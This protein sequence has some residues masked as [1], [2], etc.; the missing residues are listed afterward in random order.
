M[1]SA[2]EQ[3]LGTENSDKTKRCFE[4]TLPWTEPQNSRSSRRWNQD[5]YPHWWISSQGSDNSLQLPCCSIYFQLRAID[6]IDL[7]E[8]EVNMMGPHGP[9]EPLARLIEQLEKGREL[10]G[11]GVQTISNARMMS[12]VIT[13][14]S[15]MGMFNY[16]IRYW[17]RKYADLK[18]WEKYNLFFHRAHQEQKRAVTTAGKGGYTATVQNIY[19][20][21]LPSPEEY[22]EVIEDIKCFCKE[23]KHKDTSWKD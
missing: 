2:Q 22:H 11:A 18:T 14:L 4:N 17:R 12:K 6:E 3:A 15:Q 8:K 21:T 13:L 23:C 16:E 10:S 7:E 20:A 9:T 1:G 19:S 5:S